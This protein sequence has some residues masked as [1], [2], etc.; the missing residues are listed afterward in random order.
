MLDYI[1]CITGLRGIM[2]K[3]KKTQD[4][5]HLSQVSSGE[6]KNISHLL[7]MFIYSHIRNTFYDMFTNTLMCSEKGYIFFLYF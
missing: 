3:E 5:L 4:L 1:Y 7:R 6:W 2:K